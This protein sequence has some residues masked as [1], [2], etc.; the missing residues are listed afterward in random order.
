MTQLDDLLARSQRPGAFVERRRFTLSRD[1]AI[2]KQRE[3]ALR[4]PSQYV[5]ELVQAAVFA[6]ASY[7]A[8]DSR[9]TSVL[10]AWVG[11]RALRD[12][13]LEQILDYLFAD[14][15][16]PDVRHLVQLAVGVN[17]LLQRKPRMLRIETGDGDGALRLDL[18]IRG[19]AS[20]GR[21]EDP[22]GGTYLYA[23]LGGG[24][25][26]RFTAS[27]HT[28]EQGLIEERCLYT[29]VPILLNGGA[30]FGYRGS[31]HIEIFGAR[32]QQH[33]DTDGRRGVVAVHASPNA[34]TGFRVVVGGVWISTIDPP[35]VAAEPVVGVV[36]DDRLRKTA[37]HSDI[38]QD[39]RYVEL[40][41]ALQPPATD[42][43]RRLKGA[44]YQPPALPA[45]PRAPREERRSAPEV[46]PEPLP[47]PIECLPP[48][49]PVSLAD[50]IRALDDG[51]DTPPFC[52]APDATDAIAEAA[53]PVRF[54]YR[55]LV[56][57][58]GQAVTLEQTLERLTLHRLQSRSDVDFV[59]RVI[60]RQARVRE[61]RFPWNG[62]EVCMRLHLEGRVPDWG[63]GAGVPFLVVQEGRT[64]V[65]GA[66]IDD[67]VRVT[68]FAGQAPGTDLPEPWGLETT[69]RLPRTSLVFTGDADRLRLDADLASRILDEGWRLAIPDDGEPDRALLCALLGQI[70]VPQLHA[71]SGSGAGR[72]HA[73]AS[74][75]PDCP[76]AVR[77]IPLV[78]TTDGPLSLA[79]FLGLLGSD[80]TVELESADALQHL[81]ELEWRF[82]YGHLTHRS[83]EDR[84]I[85]G[86]GRIGN[87]WIWLDRATLWQMPGLTQM[88]WVGATFAPRLGDERWV[89]DSQPSPEL[90]AVRQ[91]D[92]PGEA[93]EEGWQLLFTR[94]YQL[95]ADDGWGLLTLPTSVRRA[96]CLGRLALLHLASQLGRDEEPLLLP[97][98][99]G[100]RRSL[101]EIRT[102]PAAR[103]VARHGVEVAEPWTFLLTL[104][105]LGA[106]DPEGQVGLRYDDAPEVWR[107][108]S[109]GE[110]T[111][112]LLRQEVRQGGLEGWLG[113]R[114]PYDGTTGILVRTT[115]RLFGL[116]EMD[117]RV[118]CHGL[119][120]S[121][122]PSSGGAAVSPEQLR[123]LQL[124]GL[125]LY[126]EVGHLL[127]SGALDPE[128]AAT[129]G[130]YGFAFAKLAWRRGRLNG[131]ALELARLVRVHDE[132]GD[133]WGTVEQW[134]Q[135]SPSARPPRPPELVLLDDPVTHAPLDEETSEEALSPIHRRLAAALLPSGLTLRLTQ[136]HAQ[137][138]APARVL[139]YRSVGGQL[140][141]F[142]D[143]D[144]GLVQKA[145]VTEGPARE[146]VLLEAARQIAQWAGSRS[147]AIDLLELQQILL[148][149][150]LDVGA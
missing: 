111:G 36:C 84:P 85:F 143:M 19:N 1:K 82:G 100:A 115:G 110:D 6:G 53:D 22:I 20:L 149:Q 54:P 77:H 57:T 58:P 125:R 103:V 134:L 81:D 135:A 42:L 48:R 18:D 129:A 56:L 141:V 49:A 95:E 64:M 26:K 107:D 24:W 144:H 147:L 45:I 104:D 138:A 52:C 38:V 113:L 108:L 128:R 133:D 86:V 74:L 59:R 66:V 33:F 27:P 29:P 87:R 43:L 5:L 96:R 136:G 73:H 41:H 79:D 106:V 8:V 67:R 12:R 127:R 50:L 124:A 17:A 99:G 98:D 71:P 7:I 16:D 139:E 9:A 105:E 126:Q 93:W 63:G 61:H 10:V 119:L 122:G 13:E 28:P 92:E 65:A 37:D 14:R 145:A 70:A 3:F 51:D 97:S 78:Q 117:R 114:H 62:G 112:W 150:R 75:P 118:P 142:L 32:D 76:D 148:A 2:E 35:E 80:R 68:A 11:G 109:D 39:H 102:D 34:P 40:L 21:V 132:G 25:F 30:P 60:E 140:V 89:L 69:L 101:A 116:P 72:P 123:L 130:L 83:L 90:V 146:V 23:E 120:R 137:G 121:L 44:R 131:T 94:L 47:E 46:A 15:G 88:I 4:H 91:A 55:V 31:R